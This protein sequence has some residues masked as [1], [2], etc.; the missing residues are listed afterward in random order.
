MLVLEV[1]EVL[2]VLLDEVVETLVVVVVV[3]VVVIDDPPP[4]V[5]LVVAAVSVVVVVADGSKTEVGGGQADADSRTRV[6]NSA[7]ESW[8]VR[9]MPNSIPI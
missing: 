6:A 1:L 7:L 9:V 8:V 5:V 4:V 3:V 2:D